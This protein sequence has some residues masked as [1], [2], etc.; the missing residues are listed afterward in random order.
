MCLMQVNC[1][2]FFEFCQIGCE[3]VLLLEPS[4]YVLESGR[5]IEVE[6]LKSDFFI[7]LGVVIRVE[8]RSDVLCFLGLLN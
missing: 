2:L 5:H 8:N 4:K 7:F 3:I 1:I 6:L